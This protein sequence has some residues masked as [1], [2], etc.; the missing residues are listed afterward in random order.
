VLG[1]QP[2]TSA[3]YTVL[4][5]DD[6]GPGSLRQAIEDAND[7]P[8]ADTITFGIDG[9]PPFTIQLGS[10]LPPITDAVTI[11]GGSQ[12]G[13]V[14][15]PLIEVKGTTDILAGFQIDAPG[16]A[17]RALAIN[18]FTGPGAAAILLAAGSA[19][20]E[21]TGNHIGVN[22]DGDEAAAPAN[23]FGVRV[24][25]D[26]NTIGG[27]APDDG[28]V[29][30]GNSAPGIYLFD[31]SDNVVEG[32]L[33]GTDIT[34]TAQ[35]ANLGGVGIQGSEA[36]Q[37]RIGGTTP[38]ARN[39]ISGNLTHQVALNLGPTSNSVVGNYIG[40]TMDG[41]A[42]LVPE[43][44]AKGVYLY[45]AGTGNAIGGAGSEGNVISGL[46][47]G[48]HVYSSS[49]TVVRGNLIG[50]D[51]EAADAI[52]NVSYGVLVEESDPVTIGGTNPGEGNVI[53]NTTEGPGI[54]VPGDYTSTTRVVIEHNSIDENFGLGIDLGDD[55][56]VTENDLSDED[57]GPNTLQNF[58]DLE[59]AT[60]T[61]V[62]GTLE[63]AAN[64]EYTVELFRV[65]DCDS[66][67][68]GE[69]ALFLAEVAV[70]TDGSGTTNFVADI[71]FQEAG[72]VTATAIHSS[73][74]TSEFSDCIEIGGGSGGTDH[75]VNSTDD[76]DDD[77]CDTDH[78]SLR[79][80]IVAANDDTGDS[81]ITFDL[82]GDSQIGLTNALPEIMDTVTIDGTT[83]PS[84]PIV[85]GQ[86]LED[87]NGLVLAA[88]SSGSRIEGLE[89]HE[90]PDEGIV[91]GSSNNAIVGNVIFD[92]RNGIVLGPSAANNDI[93]GRAADGEGNEIFTF[94]DAGVALVNAGSGNAIQGNTIGSNDGAPA[95]GGIGISVSNTP[96]TVIGDDVGPGDLGILDR[97]RG[98][99]VVAAQLPEGYG[100][101]LTGASTTGTR[102]T[103]NYVGVNRAGTSTT[104]GN[105][106][107]GIFVDGAS[108]S[109]LGP[110]N[111]VTQNGNLDTGIHIVSG[112]GNRIVANS[113]F[114][115]QGK[116]I[117]LDPGANGDLA[118]PTLTSAVPTGGG[119]ATV[120]GSISGATGSYFVEYFKNG[121][122]DPSESG[123]GETYVGFT[124]ATITGIGTTFSGDTFPG[125]ALGDVIT[126]TVT[127]SVVPEDTSEFSNCVTVE[128]GGGAL[129]P[130]VLYGAV[131]N[132]TP[133]T[134]GVA[135]VWD[136]G[137]PG[138]IEQYFDVR[139][140]SV[141]ACDPSAPKTPLG[142][143]GPLDTNAGGIGA[144]A[145]D[146]LTNV[147]VGTLV[148]ATVNTEGDSS[149]ISNC[150]VADV[151]NTS[152]PTALELTSGVPH[153]GHLRSEGQAR[154]FKLSID[155][156]T[157]VDVRLANLPADYDL[158]VFKDIQRKYDELV[159]GAPPEQGPNLALDDLNRQGAEAP[160]DAF[161]T[162][163]YNRSAWDPTNWKPDLNDNVFNPTYSPSEYSP[164][165][166]SASF[167][168]PSEYSPSEYSGPRWVPSEYSPSEYSPSE[169]SGDQY[170]PEP[171]ADFAPSDP[172][173]FSAAQTASLLAVSSTVGTGVE[174]VSV[175][176]WN[177]DGDFYVRVQ[178]KNGSFDVDDPFTLSI[179]QTGNV[180]SDVSSELLGEATPPTG[181]AGFETLILHDSSPNRWPT[182]TDLTALEARL[183][184][185]AAQSDGVV[186]DVSD[187]SVVNGLNQQADS[188]AGCPYAKNLVAARI[189]QIV[190]A[191]RSP[192][193]E[194]VVVVG[195]DDVIPFY[196]YPDP[197]LLGN[198]TLYVPPV[199][200]ASS[201][202]ASLRLGYVLSDDFVVSRT[203][204]A[205]HGND[206]P[207][208]DLA[209]G[210]LVETP[211]EIVGVIDAY[212]AA[213]GAVTP[214][215]SLVT[216]Y[217]FLTDTA[218]LVA[219]R[220]DGLVGA[221]NN[222]E[223][224][225]NSGVS[226]GV[227]GDGTNQPE[228][229]Y[230][231]R[232]WTGPDLRRELLGTGRDLIFLAGHFSANDALAADYRTN[233]LTTEV[234][235]AAADLTNT[236]VFS[237]GCHTGYNIV[238]PHRTNV[239]QP[240]DWAQAFARKRATLISGTGYQYGD[241]DFIAHSERL[242]L[243][244]AQELGGSIG[245][246][247]LRSKQRF[248]EDSPGLSAL[249]EKALLQAT[250]FGLPMLRVN[251]SPASP[252]GEAPTVSPTPVADG[253]GSELGL[254]QGDLSVSG[255]PGS[256]SSKAL[257]GLAGSA[258]WFTGSDGLSLKPM[259]PILP[260]ESSNVSVSGRALRGVLFV[261][262]SYTDTP[263]TTPLTSAPATELR[264]IHAPFQSNVFFP[265]QPWTANF[266]GALSGGGATQLHVTPVQHRSESPTMTR[267]KFTGMSFRLF[268]SNNVMSYCGNRDT[269]APC[270]PG[271]V[272][273]TPA[274]SAPPVITGVDTSYDPDTD[275][276]VFS[277]HVV[278][279]VVAGIQEVWVTYTNPQAPSP[280]WQSLEL[281]QD[282]DDPTL[283]SNADDPL[284]TAAPGAIDFMVQAVSGVGKVTLDSNLGAFYSHGSIPGPP[285]PDATL[286][287]ATQLAFVSGP[288]ASVAYKQSFQVTVDLSSMS[289]CAV[290]GKAIQI[291]IGSDGV[292]VTTNGS[293]EATVIL[294]AALTPGT[295]PLTA[296]FAGT[297]SCAASD[298]AAN[299]LVTEQATALSIALPFVTL[300]ASTTPQP[301]PL[302]DRTI[303][304]TVSQGATVKFVHVG[305]TDPQ[306][307][308]QL[309]PALLA[310][311]AQGGH[312]VLAEYDGETGY[313]AAND[314][315]GTLNVIRRG[316]GS[317]RI[318]GTAGDDLIIDTGG[319]NTIDGRGGNDVILVSGS[320][321]DKITGGDGDDTI[322]AGDGSNVVDGGA[323]NDRITT[324]SGSDSITGGS[325]SDNINAGNGSNKVSAGTGDDMIRTGSGSDSIDGGAGFDYYNAG[326]GSNSVKNC[327]G[328]LP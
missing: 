173:A 297:P 60:A 104:L 33:I 40:T 249:D 207:V 85:F 16:S 272:A 190:D 318:T 34:G 319:S 224:I 294:S 241:T 235:T 324:G 121:V 62:S 246:S 189:K 36:S 290:A 88:G 291:G 283:W 18:G 236:I 192:N 169:Y 254:E 76:D 118:A 209:I 61:S 180:C 46:G 157:R 310:A 265:P 303:V 312:T 86:A 7:N 198:E 316:S 41:T 8:G 250:L 77:T 327:E 136:S 281:E 229:Y 274:L 38:G 145:I 315:T 45:F 286:P 109:Q 314:T 1:I 100:I 225:T 234:P 273:V 227:A 72:S 165:E 57:T 167:A 151:N 258:T 12:D 143:G 279:D 65:S 6:S 89:I 210:R 80:A 75:I 53:A 155:P 112:S 66:S 69:G 170:S 223:L 177:N 176:T 105:E 263:N 264:G 44:S 255:P 2:A 39:V 304:V 108:G 124:T 74:N 320:G 49:D 237:A 30:S 221:G 188:H 123:E 243:A 120:S 23:Y 248:L 216:G 48:V 127:H 302:H 270:A 126:A 93:G 81:T 29:I 101:A 14:D 215:S 158:V 191:H 292:P 5:T 161:N 232:S 313:A 68:Y 141:T 266:F 240:L 233:V 164:S 28:N 128:A 43:N 182:G 9:T 13:Y 42:A 144:F 67:G 185:L 52:G 17:V 228:A 83:S 179:T 175:N 311:L 47:A 268:Y 25:S 116:G 11:N 130:P 10:A 54:L 187:D 37:N 32:N 142:L 139:F 22:V 288:P 321:S 299:V 218:D 322:D 293:G 326:G 282:E 99:V 84:T 220:F 154:W 317:D 242:Y 226:P 174:S 78:C 298:V 202:Q 196:R 102:V 31:A 140:Y 296:N 186:V 82:E 113:I 275:E 309:P 253:P 239:T 156:N 149:G 204:V 91:I 131:P 300:T 162:S 56:D 214:T 301:T 110:G 222:E 24:E 219:D 183:G 289:P 21:V 203:T 181:S 150:V 284:T 96:G 267:R 111:I 287:T 308:V 132:A 295:Y 197:A 328:T 212:L 119:A 251:V 95:A 55:G 64:Q 213:N 260:L 262:G 125:V 117:D 208:P 325:G 20:S 307:R 259:Q 195:G 97:Q 122:C 280:G 19:S 199:L 230:R 79:E 59:V 35:I 269:P 278:G 106:D 70:D 206:F 238:D 247:L 138:P 244:L 94:T 306:G 205:M 134:L 58:P 135:G 107:T 92:S 256:P 51:L 160:A 193:L 115:N 153:N 245:S 73:G 147:T 137:V 98:N 194:H 103:G 4:N 231:T 201:S 276:L 285:D 71:P 305:R 146:G 271:Q 133:G 63:S 172:R 252:P 166:Y 26:G 323:G 211:A 168:T 152:W 257:N 163:Q 114:A 27:T 171:W 148:T 261:G 90:F 87:G 178:G 184:T 277:A 129:D 217:D 200:E 15:V 50:T 159:G 3:A